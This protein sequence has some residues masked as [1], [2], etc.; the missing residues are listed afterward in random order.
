VADIDATLM[1]KILHVPKRKRKS[2]IHHHGQT[3]IRPLCRMSLPAHCGLSPPLPDAAVR[4]VEAAIRAERSILSAGT[5]I[6]G[7]KTTFAKASNPLRL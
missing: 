5:S 1:Q 2:N 3:D 7:I 6:S 4:P